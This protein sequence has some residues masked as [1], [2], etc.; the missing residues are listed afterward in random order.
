MVMQHIQPAYHSMRDHKCIVHL[1]T[2]LKERNKGRELELTL[3]LTGVEERPYVRDPNREY[4]P[5]C[6]IAV[7]EDI[8]IVDSNQTG[9]TSLS[10][11]EDVISV[12]KLIPN[13]F[14]PGPILPSQAALR[15]KMK[16]NNEG[17][18]NWKNTSVYL[19]PISPFGNGSYGND[20]IRVRSIADDQ[21]FQPEFVV[22]R[23]MVGFVMKQ[24]HYFHM[25]EYHGSRFESAFAYLLHYAKRAQRNITKALI[26]REIDPTHLYT[27]KRHQKQAADEYRW[28]AP[29]DNSNYHFVRPKTA[30]HDAGDLVV[31]PKN[32][33]R[34]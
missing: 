5:P 21:L 24:F 26:S 28:N 27:T 8:R 12:N 34:R 1:R 25:Q 2:G 30:S 10:L 6:V 33:N 23:P 29:T 32:W 16:E 18:E 4:I 15:A 31:L 19:Q 11:Q 7:I 22:L 20:L 13:V 17:I 9:V 14:R 3:R